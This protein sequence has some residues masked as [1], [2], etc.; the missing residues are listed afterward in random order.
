MQSHKKINSLAISAVDS[1]SSLFW[2]KYVEKHCDGPYRVH[3]YLWKM[4]K[5]EADFI[6]GDLYDFFCED[7]LVHH[8]LAGQINASLNPF[9]SEYA[10]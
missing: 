10:G 2:L 5:L 8:E 9:T 6:V 7:L 4:V 1:R 3:R